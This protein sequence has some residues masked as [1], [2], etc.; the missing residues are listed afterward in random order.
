V[1]GKWSLEPTV[2]MV[3]GHQIASPK[4]WMFGPGAAAFGLEAQPV[5]ICRRTVSDRA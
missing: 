1:T 3:A 2:V 5:T 4:V